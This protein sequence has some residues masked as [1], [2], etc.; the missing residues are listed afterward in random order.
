MSVLL[1]GALYAWRGDTFDL[2]LSPRAVA[3]IS[4]LLGVFARTR[5]RRLAGRRSSLQLLTITDGM[6]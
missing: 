3:H 4:A 6:R 5:A 1:M 2:N